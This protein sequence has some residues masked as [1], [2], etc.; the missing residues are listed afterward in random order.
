MM[1]MQSR[2]CRRRGQRRRGARP[3]A[4]GGSRRV[5]SALDMGGYGRDD[6]SSLKAFAEMTGIQKK[7]RLRHANMCPYHRFACGNFRAPNQI[8]HTRPPPSKTLAAAACGAHRRR[9]RCDVDLEEQ[10]GASV[11][12]RQARQARYALS[13][14]P[15]RQ[16]VRLQ[17]KTET[18][19]QSHT[20]R[21]QGAG[22]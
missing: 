2:Y 7:S 9:R 20:A 21:G 1:I 15:P 18:N 5:A 6:D 22:E 14:D 19:G 16:T 17:P 3:R 11:T 13:T 10:T 4:P 8:K 12:H